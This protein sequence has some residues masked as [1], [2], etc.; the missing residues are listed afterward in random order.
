MSLADVAHVPGWLVVWCYAPIETCT[1]PFVLAPGGFGPLSAAFGD[2]CRD[3]F[4]DRLTKFG[5]RVEDRFGDPIPI[6]I[7]WPIERPV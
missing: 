1:H 3:R 7:R 6:P 5:D 2:R 4:G